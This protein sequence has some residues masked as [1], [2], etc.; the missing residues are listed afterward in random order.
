MHALIV[1]TAGD[2]TSIRRFK[3]V[4]YCQPQPYR[5]L[6]VG[7]RSALR[8]VIVIRLR[9]GIARYATLL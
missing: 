3:H 4:R 7:S 1:S 9:R 8:Q 6:T 2:A 5:R